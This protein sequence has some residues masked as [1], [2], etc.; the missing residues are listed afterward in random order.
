MSAPSGIPAR[1][2]PQGVPCWIDLEVDDVD[3]ALAFYGALCGWRFAEKLPPGAPG[4]YA[5][6]SWD[7]TDATAIAAITSPSA[8]G[9]SRST[10]NT[11][12]AVDDAAASAARVLG[13]GGTLDS[14][15]EVVGPPESPA[16]HMVR[17]RDPQGVPSRL[18]QAGTR[19]GAQ[20]V[21]EPGTWNFSNLLTDDQDAALA[22]YGPLLGWTVGELGYGMV[23]VEGYG[24]HL[25][26]T[27]DPGI[28][29]RQE[30][31]PAGFADV[32]AGIGPAEGAP[33]WA[34]V[35]AVA[36]RDAAAATAVD[37]GATLLA[38]DDTEW[39]RE[40]TIRDPCGAE[41]VLSQ[42][43]PPEEYLAAEAAAEG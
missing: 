19:L 31:V 34:V 32:V 37:A 43:D 27:V 25:A 21:N 33:R 15:V 26:A 17:F 36:D 3:A 7:G 12:L 41:L 4:R 2:Y 6:A 39:T 22:F 9:A 16:G 23:R 28:L 30:H 40:A 29:D 42:F 5:V 20:R 35:L 24:A 11:Y 13:L 1:T 18:W 10:W 14:V 38:T 8:S